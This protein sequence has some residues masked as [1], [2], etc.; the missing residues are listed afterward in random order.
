MDEGKFAADFIAKNIG[1][2]FS[3]ANTIFGKLD[4]ALK[5]KLRTAYLE[6]LKTTE[7]KYSKSKSFFIRDRSV[8]LYSYYI[9]VGLA[10]KDNNVKIDTPN[11]LNCLSQSQHTVVSGLGGSGKSVLMRHLFIDCIK[12]S[13]FVPVL[14]ELRDLNAENV[15]LSKLVDSTLDTYGFKLSNEYI[16]KAKKEG[17]FSFFLDGFDEVDHSQRKKLVKDIKALLGKY[18]KC[19][20]LYQQG[21]KIY[22][23]E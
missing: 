2:I 13:N 5:L 14:I 12:Q 6:Y 23:A 17:N 21:L 11:F 16:E 1:N 19:P 15:A 20:V 9:P 7:Q 8:D 18:G 4:A 3:F 22:L 10:S